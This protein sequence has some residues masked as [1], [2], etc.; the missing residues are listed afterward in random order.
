MKSN[1]YEQIPENLKDEFFEVLASSKS[2]KIEKIVSFGHSTPRDEWY[3]Q[4]QNEWVVLLKGEAVLLFENEKEIRLL[5]GDFINIPA[6][7]K[8]RV[9]W[10]K[11][12]EKTIWLAVF[13]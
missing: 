6:H 13:Y 2:V 3:D 7:K 8:H 4:E 5:E 10:T 11:P 12:S 1:I 9:L